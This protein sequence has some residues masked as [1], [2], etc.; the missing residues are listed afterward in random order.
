MM[1]RPRSF[2]DDEDCDDDERDPPRRH[3]QLDQRDPRS[4]DHHRRI[5]M[6]RSESF[7]SASSRRD[8]FPKGFRSD[9]REHHG[10]HQHRRDRRFSSPSPSP[11]SSSSPLMRRF[12]SNESSDRHQYQ[13]GRD[14]DLRSSRDSS[15]GEPPKATE[16]E[17]KA[18]V[19]DSC[20]ARSSS[21]SE[22]EEGELQPEPE[23][24]EI[25]SSVVPD[26]DA[27]TDK[28]EERRIVS[29][30]GN[31]DG[32]GNGNAEVK[33]LNDNNN[34][35][36]EESGKKKEAILVEEEK[37]A[38]EECAVEQVTVINME[39]SKMNK[40]EGD[41][42]VE[43]ETEGAVEKGPSENSRDEDEPTTDSKLVTLDEPPPPPLQ[44]NHKDK[45][46]SVALSPPRAEDP[47]E[48]EEGPSSRRGFDLFFISDDAKES[49]SRTSTGKH[50]DDR[51][52]LEA[53]DLSLGLPGI[54]PDHVLK[55]PDARPGSPSLV[56]SLHSMPSS[57][58]TGS[59]GFTTSISFSGSQTFLHNPSCSLTQNSVDYE[60]SVGSH[61]LFQ[62]ADQ[63]SGSTIWQTQASNEPKWKG[64]IGIGTGPLLQ[65]VLVNG[66]TQ[67]VKPDDLT[68]Q[69]SLPRQLSPTLSHGSRGDTKSEHSKDKRLLTRERSSSSLFR[70]D[71]KEGEQLVLNA[72]GF[73]RILSKIVS[74]P[75][76]AV[77]RLLQEMTDHSV[78]Y[79]KEAICEMVISADKRNNLHTLQEAL[80]RRLD[81][82]VET[83]SKC[84]RTLLEILVALKTGLPDLLRRSSSNVPSSDL[85]EIFH[86]LK[87]RNLSCRTILPVD[88][89]ECKVCKQI[90]GFCSSCMCLVCSKFDNASNTCGWVGC[91]VCI[92]W[93]HTDCGLQGSHIRN[94]PC[95]GIQGMTEMQ[96]HCVACNHPSE[97]FGFVKDVFMTCVKDWKAET[98]VK[99]LQY[100]RRIFA[101]SNDLKGRRLCAMANQMLQKIEVKANISEVI[102]II[103]GFFSE[104]E[105]NINNNPSVTPPKEP[106]RNVAEGS[107]G[108]TFPTKE[109]TWLPPFSSDRVSHRENTGTLSLFD[110]SQLGRQT[111]DAE[112]Q[113]RPEKKPVVDEL[114]SV[115]R[116]KQAEARMYQ[117][118]ADSA[119][120]EAEGL[121]RIA[122]AKNVQVEE[123]YATKTAKLQ[124]SEAEE[125]RRKK[126][127]E[128]QVIERAH[129]EY[130]NMKMRMES[131]I[132][133]LLLKMEATKRNFST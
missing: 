63:V 25:L 33:E 67:V 124:L 30:N 36:N 72:A 94:G 5:T 24:E 19:G 22:M 55:R 92:H 83:M 71:Q 8:F 62:G 42:V 131:E 101:A 69:C 7:S 78:S 20:S 97:M 122:I 111:K 73:E 113:M 84:P 59:D 52:E 127:E 17:A 90:S 89:C 3:R 133:D 68:R 41:K 61:P 14:R 65:R 107:N 105:V 76:Q 43:A 102:N 91:D 112:I 120:R 39:T 126:V 1:K 88:D 31:G 74:E 129:R 21:S 28:K 106:S 44:E 47:V 29:T 114:E 130:F 100:V 27:G 75:M 125:R 119:R 34:G 11:S 98:L 12:G 79:L 56:K 66:N 18:V 51:L 2:D 49:S 16:E 77:G 70:S 96:F 80:K 123:E 53:L 10:H 121:K 23:N 118:R 35:E 37:C 9:R 40:E 117:E 99:E 57:F 26:E 48:R 81:L 93:C 4:F 13:D 116:F 95:S 103:S 110:Y 82:T 115:V 50:E 38:G 85:V 15:S 45:G 86:N 104:S 128:L 54:P 64:G 132:N 58:R 46:K 32:D 60:Q 87:C 108:A 6:H 109:L